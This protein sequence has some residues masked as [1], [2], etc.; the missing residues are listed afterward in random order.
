MEEEC[1][2]SHK[3]YRV[4]KDY[5]ERVNKG[6]AHLTLH[7]VR[8]VKGSKKVFYRYIRNKRKISKKFGL[9]D[10]A[11]RKGQCI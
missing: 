1:K 2:L 9:G 4:F 8:D 3:E 11:P 5:R 10:K 7:L 6:K